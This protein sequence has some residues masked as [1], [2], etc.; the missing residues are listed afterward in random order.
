[1][2]G[3]TT[4]DNINLKTD[5][6]VEYLSQQIPHPGH[7]QFGDPPPTHCNSN[8]TFGMNFLGNR[9]NELLGDTDLT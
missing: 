5:A 1:M 7:K 3:E 6:Q 8:K 9:F 4:D 2:R